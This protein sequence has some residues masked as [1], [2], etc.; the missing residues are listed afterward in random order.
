M[1]RSSPQKCE[2]RR[3]RLLK[4]K[5][6]AVESQQKRVE[7]IQVEAK[8]ARI[9]NRHSTQFSRSAWQALQPP[10]NMM[11]QPSTKPVLNEDQ[12]FQTQKWRPHEDSQ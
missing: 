9:E 11:Q 6:R 8:T 5:R 1:S 12:G 3:K 2:R 7:K 10:N 4:K